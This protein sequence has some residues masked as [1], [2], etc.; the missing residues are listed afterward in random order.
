MN[1]LIEDSEHKINDDSFSLRTLRSLLESKGYDKSGTPLGIEDAKIY[2]LRYLFPCE[3]GVILNANGRLEFK[4]CDTMNKTYYSRIDKILMRWFKTQ[5]LDIY[6]RVCIPGRQLVLD[7]TINVVGRFKHDIDIKYKDIRKK[8]RQRVDKVINFIREVWCSDDEKQLNYIL[9]WIATVCQGKKNSSILYA[10]TITEGVGKSSL[11]D[12]LK[13]YVIGN[14]LSVPGDSSMLKTGNN[15]ALYGKVLVTFEELASTYA[16]WNK[17]SAALKEWATSTTIQYNEKY[18]VGFSG[19]NINN[20]I[21]NTNTEAV[22]GANGRRYFI[23]DL[24]TKYVGDVD[25]WTDLHD[26]IMRDDVGKAFFIL[27]NERDISNYKSNVFPVTTK[28][29]EYISE[30]LNP[31]HKFIK[32]NYLLCNKEI[33]KVSTKELYENYKTFCS[34]LEIK[35]MTQRS[36]NGAMSELNFKYKVSNSKMFYN[37]S[38]DDLKDVASKRNWL[39]DMDADQLEENTIWDDVKTVSEKASK[40]NLFFNAKQYEDIIDAKDR[41]IETKDKEI[42][43]KDREIEELKKQ[44]AELQKPKT[45]KTKSP[46][47]KKEKTPKKQNKIIIDPSNSLI[48]AFVDI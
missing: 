6:S 43:A 12:F 24:S 46:K 25:Y 16:E 44:L 35:I 22:K 20:Y 47:T 34:N 42:E 17:I 48:S 21:I 30:L 7:N 11:S 13:D 3:G 29:K 26:N 14:R 31:V 41:V 2:M 1:R 10:K 27:M 23:C 40:N 8:T 19:N 5:T 33:K 38:L 36:F 45:K 32:F 39:S 18:M 4:S 15:Y 28:K 37:I 9:D